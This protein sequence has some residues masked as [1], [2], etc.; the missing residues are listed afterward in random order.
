MQIRRST[1][2]NIRDAAQNKQVMFFYFLRSKYFHNV[3]LDYKPEKL[4]KLTHVSPNTVRK[5]IHYLVENEYLIRQGKNLVFRK[6]QKQKGVWISKIETRPWTSFD[7][8]KRR[9]YTKLI[10]IHQAQQAWNG[11]IKA[12]Y[13]RNINNS[14]S[15]VDFKQL[16]TFYKKFKVGDGWSERIFLSSRSLALIFNCSPSKVLKIL[17]ELK[18]N[19][20]IKMKCVVTNTNF[21]V[22]DF[23]ILKKHDLLPNGFFYINDGRVLHHQGVN[24]KVLK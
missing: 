6:T 21:N 7:A 17:K 24:I 23:F 1:K 2:I 12:N 16:K 13:H 11:K 9:V 3:I 20:Y 22:N 15:K 14:K 8:F 18:R 4:A 5:Y 19:K 10:K